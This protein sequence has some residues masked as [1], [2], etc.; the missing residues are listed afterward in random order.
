MTCEHSADIFSIVL[1]S[2]D[3]QFSDPAVIERVI[4][5]PERRKKRLTIVESS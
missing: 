3:K 2:L 5:E 1:S 4:G